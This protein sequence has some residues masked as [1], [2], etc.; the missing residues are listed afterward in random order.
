MTTIFH[1]EDEIN[2][3][4]RAGKLAC[5][6]LEMIEPYVKPGVT[7]DELDR[8]C[9]DYIVNTQQA[10]PAPLNYKGFP[11]S[12]CISVNHVICHGIPG[13]KKLKKGDILNIDVTVIKDGY[14]GD[15]SKMFTVGEPS[16]RAQRLIDVTQQCLYRGIEQV[17]PGAHIGDIG[18]AI[19]AHAEQH[20]Y[21]VVREFC[22]H[23]I[24]TVFHAPPNVVHFGKPGSGAQIQQGQCFTIEP[25]INAGTRHMKILRDGWTAITKDRQLSAQWEHTLLV[26]QDGVEILTLRD[27]EKR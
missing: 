21:S 10:I 11:K 7:T 25:M 17:K 15:T 3:M 22:G 13:P 20:R 23:G 14:H 24:G 16:I 8:I 1:T 5:E 26:T 2:Q 27:E 9:H 19:Q 12:V 4:R 6:V 18:A